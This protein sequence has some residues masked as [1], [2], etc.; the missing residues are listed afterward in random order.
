MANHDQALAQLSDHVRKTAMLESINSLL[1]WDERTYMPEL[2]GPYR[3]EQITWVSAMLHERKTDARLADWLNDLADHPA[4]ADPHSDIA[5][6]IREVRREFDKQNKLPQR[7]VEE[8]ARYSVTGQQAWVEA[9]R[10]NDFGKLRP[11]LEKIVALKREQAEAVGYKQHPYDALLDDY[12]PN[13]TTAEVKQTL[14]ELRSELVPLVQAI[15]ES[16][17]TPPVEILHALYPTSA[18]E[19]FGK[20]AAAAIGFDFHRGRLDVTH[21]PFCTEMGPHDCRITTR[22]DEHFFSSAFFGILH[23][24]GHGLYELGRRPEEYGMPTGQYVSLGIHESQ[25]R[26]WENQVGRSQAFWQHFF[27]LA[28]QQ[29]PAA[30]GKVKQDDFFFAINE[31][32]P[33]LIRVE[34]DEATYNLHIIIRFELEQALIVGDLAV[35]DL[36][37]AWN[38][39]YREY[40]GVV[41]PNDADGVLQDIHWPAALFGYFPTYSLGNLYA[42]QFFEQA[43]QDLG[44]LASL[45]SRGEFAPLLK[46]LQDKIHRYGRCFSPAELVERATAKP[47]SHEPLIR[48]LRGKLAPLYQL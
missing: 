15:R 32:K 33:S 28:K 10:D 39:K 11:F 41:P 30:L 13:A 45:I 19:E 47:L 21:H 1:N 36:P 2:A 18:Q 42:A 44:G 37:Q 40:L 4:C 27:P 3:A 16:K 12:E 22:Y 6:T 25:S 38:D 46:W 5:T 35:A 31:V 14:S 9:R 26:L 24:A 34:A 48:H 8:L 23:E 29:F 17:Q 20:Q 43:D 7:L